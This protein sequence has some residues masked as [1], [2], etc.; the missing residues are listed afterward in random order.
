MQR[1]GN[2]VSDSSLYVPVII[3]NEQCLLSEEESDTNFCQQVVVITD[4]KFGD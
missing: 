3:G 4:G 1:S 2:H